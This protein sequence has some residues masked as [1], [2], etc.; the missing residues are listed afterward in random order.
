MSPVPAAEEGDLLLVATFAKPRFELLSRAQFQIDE[1]LYTGLVPWGARLDQ[2]KRGGGATPAEAVVELSI[3]NFH[4][5]IKL[6]IDRLEIQYLGRKETD[7]VELFAVA[8]A[9]E[10]ALRKTWPDFGWKSARLDIRMHSSKHSPAK[11]IKRYT[12]AVPE[13][14]TLLAQGTSFYF[15]PTGS[16]A[17]GPANVGLVLEP[18]EVVSDGVFLR[19]WMTWSP[20]T[21]LDQLA[22]SS[23]EFAA[24]CSEKLGVKLL[25]G[26]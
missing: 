9:C 7:R 10:G 11:F 1:A 19:L 5:G 6:F 26:S 23:Q 2:L 12:G 13:L 25:S 18:S 16:S 4:I 20:V 17:T 3:L 8:A 24:L 14:G 22:P 21:A 15:A